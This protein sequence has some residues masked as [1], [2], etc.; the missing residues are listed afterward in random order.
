[1]PETQNP[2]FVTAFATM[3]QS[4]SCVGLIILGTKFIS[5]AGILPAGGPGTRFLKQG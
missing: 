5:R 4:D 2:G 3:T 1:M